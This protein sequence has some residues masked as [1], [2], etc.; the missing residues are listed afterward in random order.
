MLEAINVDRQTQGLPTVEWNVTAATAG[1][2]HAEDMLT[3]GY[4]SHWDLSGYGPEYRYAMA[5]G[6]D[7][8]AENIYMYWYRYDNGQPAP[9]EDWGKVIREAEASLMTSPGHRRN[10]LDSSHTH[11]GVGIAYDAQKGELRLVQEF[12]NRWVRIDLQ[13]GQLRVGTEVRVTG[14]L[15]SGAT[16]PTINLTYQPFPPASTA[17]TVPAGSYR[18]VAEIYEAINPDVTGERFASQF[19]LNYKG[20]KGLYSVRTWVEV[21][22]QSVLASE[23]IL[24][25]D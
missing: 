21:A 12:I 8:V 1:Q 7:A 10:I 18:S 2:V 14:V 5:G 22:G 4:F 19:R 9:I 15:L 25:T 13:P 11:V 6:V 20:Q 23:V 3:K 17:Q 16:N 24:R